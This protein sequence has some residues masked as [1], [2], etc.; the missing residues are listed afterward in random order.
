MLCD[1]VW[2]AVRSGLIDESAPS[3]A[4]AIAKDNAE[5]VGNTRDGAAIGVAKRVADGFF[6]DLFRGAAPD[7]AEFVTQAQVIAMAEAIKTCA[8]TFFLKIEE[9]ARHF[10]VDAAAFEDTLMDHQLYYPGP[11]VQLQIG[12]SPYCSGSAYLF[13]T[14]F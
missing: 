6:A 7:V 4:A 5:A 3:L 10:A 8:G 1:P 11:L 14:R 9:A 13:F 12:H 2:V